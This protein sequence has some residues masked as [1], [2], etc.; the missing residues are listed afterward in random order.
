V[1]R[2]YGSERSEVLSIHLNP[3]KD[4]DKCQAI[5][6]YAN[7]LTEAKPEHH[8]TLRWMFAEYRVSSF[9]LALGIAL[10]LEVL[11]VPSLRCRMKSNA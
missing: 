6:Q 1:G 11:L 9:A 3:A 10:N 4:A 8:E 2:D 7:W 5:A